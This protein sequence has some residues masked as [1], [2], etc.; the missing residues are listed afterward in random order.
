MRPF[1]YEAVGD[2]FIPSKLAR[3]P[4]ARDK[5]NGVAMGGLLVH[6]LEQMPLDVPM[7]MARLTIDI[8]AAAPWSATM[9]QTRIVRAGKRIRLAEAE[10]LVEGAV[11]ARA[12]A[13]YVRIAETPVHLAPSLYPSAEKAGSQPFEGIPSFLG[14]VEAI[15]V[16]GSMRERGPATAWVRFNHEH[17]A[18]IPL[19]PLVRAATLAD[20]SSGMSHDFDRPAWNF[21]NLDIVIHFI[22]APEGEWMLMDARSESAG[23]GTGLAGAV[24]ADTRGKFARSYQTLFVSPL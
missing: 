18:G 10:L 11:V 22:R 15:S 2:A 20:F 5:Q 17:I 12:T 9:G 4:W 14:T 19:S 3:S 16:H 23:N 8:L 13:L 24:L 1:V 7:T 6:L 21:P